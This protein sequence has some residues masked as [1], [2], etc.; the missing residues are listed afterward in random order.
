MHSLKADYLPWSLV[1]SPERCHLS[2]GGELKRSLRMAPERH[3]PPPPPIGRFR[4]HL[5]LKKSKCCETVVLGDLAAVSLP[6]PRSLEQRDVGRCTLPPLTLQSK[7]S[8]VSISQFIL[9]VLSL[10][11]S[12][13]QMNGKVFLTYLFT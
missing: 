8:E 9:R 1:L 4:L 2:T 10:H 13:F 6:Q 11:V 7:G 5:L 3:N 12:P